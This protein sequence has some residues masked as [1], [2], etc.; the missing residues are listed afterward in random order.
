MKGYGANPVTL[1]FDSP[2]AE[3]YRSLER[4]VFQFSFAKNHEQLKAATLALHQ[5]DKVVP[6]DEFKGIV[7]RINQEYNVRFL[8][9]EYDTAI[10]SAQMASRWVQFTKDDIDQLTYRTVGDDRVRPSHQA[11][12]GVTR[13]KSD[14]FW[15]TYYPPNG[16]NCRCDAEQAPNGKA[17]PKNKIPIPDDVPKIFQTNFA[18]NGLA[19]P[20]DHP[21]LEHVPD[22]VLQAA[23]DNNPFNYDQV[24]KGKKNG[25]V[26][27]SALHGND[28]LADNLTIARYYANQGNQVILL[29]NIDPNSPEQNALRKMTLPANV[30][31][32]KNADALINGR[33]NEFKTNKEGTVNSIRNQVRKSLKQADDATIMMTKDDLKPANIKKAIREQLLLS[34]KGKTDALKDRT[35][36]VIRKG[37]GTVYKLDEL[38]K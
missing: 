12:D 14:S 20:D 19:F 4:N 3:M 6:F 34:F 16:W 22:E 36:T 30:G 29:P 23:D 33:T 28:E 18:A 24:Y 32:G 38:I 7:S 5:G 15:K 11:L 27:K 8:R 37:K 17:T 10:G 13:P 31:K 25:S 26:W 35:I 21:Y 9:T 1:D 2:D